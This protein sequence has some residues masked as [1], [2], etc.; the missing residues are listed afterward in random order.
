MQKLSL[1][2]TD[3][4]VFKN[5]FDQETLIELCKKE[6]FGVGGPAFS[7][8]RDLHRD[9][10]WK[11][12][13]NWFEDCLEEIK[14]AGQ[15][16]CDKISITSSWCN[17]YYAKDYNYHRPH[18]HSLSYLSAVYY[19]TAGA[20]TLFQDPLPWR[21][22]YAQIEV[23]QHNFSPLEEVSAEPGKLVIFPSWMFHST[24]QH[25]DDFDR[26]SISF[27]TLP[28]GNVNTNMASDSTATIEI[29]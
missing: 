21:A 3:L 13:F 1:F 10:E 26:W 16:D 5:D 27:N 28:S 11:E 6:Q 12:L 19:L 7:S 22:E 18:R 4:F 8:R 2:P 29:K 17:I 15:M 25:A 24:K 9:K 20:P 14:V 23:L